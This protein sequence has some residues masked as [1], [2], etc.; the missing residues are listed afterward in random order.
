MTSRSWLDRYNLL[1]LDEIDSTNLEARRIAESGV[2]NNFVIWAKKQTQG[3]G[4]QG[5][6]WQSLSN[7]LYL[8][9]LLNADSFYNKQSELCFVAG[10]AAQ[11]VIEEKLCEAG[12][13]FDIALKWPND[14]MV[15]GAKISGILLEAIKIKNKHS[16]IIG[17][18]INIHNHPKDLDRSTTSLNDL[19]RQHSD[20]PEIEAQK[21]LDLTM[22]YFEYYYALWQNE[23]FSK[24]RELWLEKAYNPGGILTASYGAQKI[25]GLFQDIDMQG[26]LRI[27]LPSGEI[28]TLVAGE[29][30]IDK[31]EI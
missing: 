18:G 24:I 23:G 11:K 26:S 2:D 3:K 16:L 14:V 5:K 25:S 28:H 9:I 22:Q 15:D 27:K 10:L 12:R 21:I 29:I 19:G 30:I 4:R 20:A 6:S 8:S 31:K 1:V 7:N 13:K 17:I